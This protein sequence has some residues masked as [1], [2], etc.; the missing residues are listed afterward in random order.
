MKA[1]LTKPV[2]HDYFKLSFKC[3]YTSFT[4]LKNRNIIRKNFTRYYQIVEFYRIPVSGTSLVSS[5]I[6]EK[7]CESLTGIE[8]VTFWLLVRSSNHL[9]YLYT[10]T[11]MEIEGYNVY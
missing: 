6:L 3:L 1:R 9:S 10:R 11:Q 4:N 8:P 5:L 7:T 2:K